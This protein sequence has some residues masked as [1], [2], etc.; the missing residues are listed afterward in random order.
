M[1]G[2]VEPVTYYKPS[3]AIAGVIFYTGDKFPLWK[4]HLIAGALV[5]TQLTRIQFNRQGLETRREAMLT[6]LH[7]RIRD[8]R[9]GPDGLIYL[10]TD[11]P[12]GAVL[13]LEPVAEP[14]TA[15]PMAGEPPAR[16]VAYDNVQI[17][18]CMAN[19]LFPKHFGIRH[20]HA[21]PRAPH[22]S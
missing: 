11:M 8:V 19:R 3:I 2:M 15:A 9:Q 10:T 12:D 18:V 17:N 7:Q 13:K 4:G 5:G 21:A 16:A 14:L 20:A 6:E 1:K 22:V